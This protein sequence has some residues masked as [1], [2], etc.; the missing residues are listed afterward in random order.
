MLAVAQ[1]EVPSRDG[2]ARLLAFSL[3]AAAARGLSRRQ[4]ALALG[5]APPL[6]YAWSD[7]QSFPSLA[8]C[9]DVCLQ[10]RADPGEVIRP[11]FDLRCHTWPPPG[12]SNLDRVDDVW[13]FAL[14][15]RECANEGLHPRW[16]AH[17]DALASTPLAS[18][19][20]TGALLD[21]LTHHVHILE[22][23]GESFRLNH[24]RARKTAPTG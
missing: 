16:A 23:N 17:L 13:E 24:S 21:R 10:L 3:D 15:A 22:M 14:R 4:L 1:R 6:F 2:F 19:R 12:D 9:A 5:V 20:L 18:Q 7:G 8:V 11:A